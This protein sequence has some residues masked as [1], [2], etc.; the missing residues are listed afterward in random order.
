MPDPQNPMD[1]MGSMA[2]SVERNP[3]AFGTGAA[4]TG[5]K[6]FTDWSDHD[7]YWREHYASRPYAAGDRSYDHYR[8]AYQF[9]HAAAQRHAGKR[10]DEAELHLMKEWDAAK[11]ESKSAWHEVKD[12]VRDAWDRVTGHGDDASRR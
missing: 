12:A 2:N 1:P 8:P 6:G 9:G 4:G 3:G 7:A 11:G 10:W 5:S